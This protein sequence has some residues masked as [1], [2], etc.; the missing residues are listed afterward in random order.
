MD[1]LLTLVYSMLIAIT[2]LL[3]PLSDLII[4]HLLS[5]DCCLLI[6]ASLDGVLAVL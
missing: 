5:V 1:N 6:V 4:S 2:C 3:C